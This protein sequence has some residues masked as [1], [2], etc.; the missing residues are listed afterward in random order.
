VTPPIAQG[1][2]MLPTADTA[3]A[4]P[5]LDLDALAKHWG[6]RAR[7]RPMTGEEMR[8]ADARAQRMGVS[9]D[10][11]MEQ[12]GAAVAAAARALMNSAERPLTGVVLILCG[13][14]NNGGDGLV[15][16]RHLAHAG[17]R[18]AAVLIS[19]DERPSTADAA[20]NWERLEGLED[21]DRIQAATPR[22]VGM[23]AKGIERASLIVDALLG[24]GVRGSLREPIR[25]AVELAR[26]GREAGVPVLAV[27][28]P[29]ALDL[30]SGTPSDP[31][32]RADATITFHRPKEGLLSR[33]GEAL[34]GRVLVA[35]IGIP[36]AA[37]PT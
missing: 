8:G 34:A 28:T 24:T 32:V 27:D 9:G 25:S 33:A 3:L 2:E 11:L 19:S 23:L 22:D 10:R 21:V 15:A 14:G 18:S 13:P 37:D 12:A 29:T 16:A 1:E 6:P 30:S 31:N 36:S 17:V 5:E 26:L 4:D 35:P 20:R 7:M